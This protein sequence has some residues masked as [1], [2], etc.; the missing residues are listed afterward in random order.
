MEGFVNGDFFPV[1]IALIALLL[2]LWGFILYIKS[3]IN[4]AKADK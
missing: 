4:A 2:L 1:I 3:L